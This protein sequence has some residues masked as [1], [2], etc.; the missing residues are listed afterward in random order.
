[1]PPDLSVA[2]ALSTQHVPTSPVLCTK[3][4]TPATI[5]VAAHHAAPATYTP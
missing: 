2:R 4:P 5:L 3:S 1:V